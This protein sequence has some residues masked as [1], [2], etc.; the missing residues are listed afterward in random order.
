[1]Y[2]IVWDNS[3]EWD[4]SCQEVNT[5]EHTRVDPVFD[6]WSKNLDNTRPKRILSIHP[7]LKLFQSQVLK[8]S[9]SQSHTPL[10]ATTQPENETYF[11]PTHF[12]FKTIS[13]VFPWGVS[14]I[15]DIT[16][17]YTLKAWSRYKDH[18]QLCIFALFSTGISCQHLYR[19]HHLA[20]INVLVMG[21]LTLRSVKMLNQLWPKSYI[22]RCHRQNLVVL[23]YLTK[24]R[25][26]YSACDQVTWRGRSRNMMILKSRKPK[27]PWDGGDPNPRWVKGQLL[28]WKEIWTF[29]A[30]SW[31]T[32]LS[33]K[34]DKYG[35]GQLI[36]VK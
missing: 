9:K 19:L 31:H 32:R 4:H 2:R 29:L 26:E 28:T 13:F 6:I 12:A 21:N 20:G 16:E 22:A 34:H 17:H 33:N 14:N 11:D 1:M 23:I 30:Q 7:I 18:L 35:S 36:Q 27:H 25:V 8:Y 3:T 15:S 24:S 5:F 10:K